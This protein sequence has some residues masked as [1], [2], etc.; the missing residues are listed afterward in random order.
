ME[1]IRGTS[2]EQYVPLLCCEIYCIARTAFRTGQHDLG[3]RGLELLRAH[4]YRKYPGRP[5]HRIAASALGLE[6][7]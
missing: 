6:P 1:S 2:F 3:R 4:K 7:R 5:L